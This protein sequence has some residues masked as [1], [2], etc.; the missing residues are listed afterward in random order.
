MANDHSPKLG[1]ND[2]CPVCGRKMKHCSG[3]QRKFPPWVAV[4][5]S[6]T[7]LIFAL[8]AGLATIWW[9]RERAVPNPAP[10]STTPAGSSAAITQLQ[11]LL[12]D[13]FRGRP[14]DTWWFTTWPPQPEEF[15]AT[16]A[17]CDEIQQRIT[18]LVTTYRDVTPLTREIASAFPRFRVSVYYQG[19]SH[20]LLLVP[21]PEAAL[22]PPDSFEVCLI[23]LSEMTNDLRSTLLYRREWRAIMAAGFDWPDTAFAALLYHELGH[24]LRHRQSAPSAFAELHEDLYA[25]EENEM[26]WLEA[27]VINAATYGA[28][29]S[30]LDDVI[31]R[32]PPGA[33]Y[34]AVILG[35]RLD[36][37]RRID[38]LLGGPKV[39]AGVANLLQYEY[40]A[41]L[42][43][44]LIRTTR[45][46]VTW[47][48]QERE[49][50]RW[51]EQH[52][53]SR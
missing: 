26:Y 12:D 41:A 31:K 9:V 11:R 32:Q 6:F 35:L 34:Q 16:I 46:P 37:F 50:Y 18:A 25:D 23:P 7:L 13:H 4:R 30:T 22:P 3:H 19:I 48:A 28:F 15:P 33:G 21:N 1:R 20:Q 8:L 43:Q 51:L 47:A 42:G 5:L 49:L 27:E 36:D 39:T 38:E 10:Q 2:P 17:R 44:R 24:A 29:F 40:L 14:W 53:V 52:F 45:P